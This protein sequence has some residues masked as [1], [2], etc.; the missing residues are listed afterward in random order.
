VSHIGKWHARPRF[1]L[2][3]FLLPSFP[4]S[5]PPYL[6]TYLECEHL[7]NASAIDQIHVDLSNNKMR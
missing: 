1:S 3:P 5:F 6:P 2:L 7:R 4:P